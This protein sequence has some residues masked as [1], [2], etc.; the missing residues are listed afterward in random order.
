MRSNMTKHWRTLLKVAIRRVE[1][2]RDWAP[3]CA[4][5]YS[6][7]TRRLWTVQSGDIVNPRASSHVYELPL[8]CPLCFWFAIMDSVSG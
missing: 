2:I 1:V 8:I 4:M 3:H 7:Q 5:P 6:E